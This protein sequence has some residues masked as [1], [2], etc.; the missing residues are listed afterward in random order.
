M[1]GGFFQ[2]LRFMGDLFR[3]HFLIRIWC[4]KPQMYLFH[5]HVKLWCGTTW[6]MLILDMKTNHINIF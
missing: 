2:T 4:P 5:I 6:K 1:L 3:V